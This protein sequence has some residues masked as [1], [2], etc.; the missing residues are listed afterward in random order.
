MFLFQLDLIYATLG[1]KTEIA[2]DNIERYN[3]FP[4][5]EV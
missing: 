3:S 4:Y 1:N 5:Y 2:M